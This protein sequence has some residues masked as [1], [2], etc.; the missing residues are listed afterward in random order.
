MAFKI[1][2]TNVGLTVAQAKV[3]DDLNKDCKIQKGH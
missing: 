3:I 2:G 1:M